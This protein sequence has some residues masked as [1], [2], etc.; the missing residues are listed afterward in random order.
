M[1]RGFYYAMKAR[2]MGPRE[3]CLGLNRIII[4]AADEAAWLEARANPRG[5]E[6]RLIAEIEAMRK[7][8]G[9][10]AGSAAAA[11]PRHISKRRKPQSTEAA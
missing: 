11:S 8:R 3:T 9:R 6:A 4:T 10:R 5:T 2:G 1:S 7:A